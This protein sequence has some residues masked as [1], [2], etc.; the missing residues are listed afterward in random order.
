MCSA[1]NPM[2]WPAALN[3][4]FTIDPISPGSR[5]PSFALISFRPFPKALPVAFEE[6]VIEPTTAPIGTPA[7]RRIAVAVTPYL[8]KISLT[9]SER[10]RAL[11]LSAI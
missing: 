10:G 8:L 7:A 4:K 11:S 3:R 1:R 5:E 6:F 2:A 9:L